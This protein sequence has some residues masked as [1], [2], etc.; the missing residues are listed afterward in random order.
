MRINP[1]NLTLRQL[2]AFRSVARARSF[3]LAARALHITPSALSELIK[4]LES[5]IGARLFDRTTRKV[6]LTVVGE[7]FLDDVDRV[8]N[9]LEEALQRIHEGIVGDGWVKIVGSPS[10]L[11]GIVMPSLASL[12]ERYPKVKVSLIEGGANEIFDGVITG[13][14]DFGIGSINPEH[15]SELECLALFNDR[16][17]LVGSAEHPALR[18]T[19]KTVELSELEG[20][21]F[22]GLTANTLIDQMLASYKNAPVSVI[23]PVMRVSNPTLLIAALQ[24]N[25][26]V[27]VLTALTCHFVDNPK[28]A[29]KLFSDVRLARRIQLFRRVNRTLSPPAMIVWNEVYRNKSLGQSINGLTVEG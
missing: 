9:D 17:G 23:E 26:G 11:K 29:F 1:N 15:E 27:S 25:L 24:G 22:I 28:I 8:V 18:S 16:L 19:K 10:A 5:V 2:R 6:S 21:H 3:S 13:G 7:Q 4:Q 20:Q 14:A 12:R